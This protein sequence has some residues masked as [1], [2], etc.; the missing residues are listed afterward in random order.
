MLKQTPAFTPA[1]QNRVAL[2][3]INDS[4]VLMVP[5]THLKNKNTIDRSMSFW[6]MDL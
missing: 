2:L 6:I 4:V 1:F 5:K 3:L